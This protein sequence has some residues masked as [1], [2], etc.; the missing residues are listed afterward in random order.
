MRMWSIDWVASSGHPVVL[1]SW[2][3]T[4]GG[5]S[6][7]SGR[8]L[9]VEAC[10]TYTNTRWLVI[11]LKWLHPCRTYWSLKEN[12]SKRQQILG[13]WWEWKMHHSMCWNWANVEQ[14]ARCWRRNGDKG[15]PELWPVLWWMITWLSLYQS[16]NFASFASFDSLDPLSLEIKRDRW[17]I[18]DNIIVRSRLLVCIFRSIGTFKWTPSSDNH[19]CT[20]TLFYR[21]TVDCWYLL[22]AQIL[23][24]MEKKPCK[25]LDKPTI[26]WCRMLP[27]THS[28]GHSEWTASPQ[29]ILG[30]L[31]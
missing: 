21:H 1:W 24:H 16:R 31:G 15:W 17:H 20:L 22:M 29:I 3:G 10:W 5:N 7:E 11:K 23:H 27:Y 12:P 4:A 6:W 19:N 14:L 18:G 13:F 26:N 8:R 2:K 25:W 28:I 9:T 30:P